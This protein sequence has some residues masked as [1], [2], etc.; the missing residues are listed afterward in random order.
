LTAAAWV[1]AGRTGDPVANKDDQAR[2]C[3]G[4]ALDPGRSH[5]LDEKGGDNAGRVIRRAG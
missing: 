2:W 4:I 5:L 1:N 3:A